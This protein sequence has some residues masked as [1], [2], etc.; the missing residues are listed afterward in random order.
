MYYSAPELALEGGR[1]G[2]GLETLLHPLDTLNPINGHLDISGECPNQE[3]ENSSEDESPNQINGSS[4]EDGSSQ[5]QTIDF[6]PLSSPVP[7]H[8]K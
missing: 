6:E 7:Q 3:N 1:D 5:D 4:S 2:G 8:H